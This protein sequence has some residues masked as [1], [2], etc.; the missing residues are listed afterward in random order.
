MQAVERAWDIEM[1]TKQLIGSVIDTIFKIVIIAVMVMFTYKYATEAYDFGYR[2][3]AEEP[4]SSPETAKAISIAI[5]EEAS[6]M[7]IGTVLEEKGLINDARLFYVQEMLSKYH[8]EIRPGI[9]ELSSDM[10]A[11]EMM[12]VMATPPAEE[13]PGDGA[14]AEGGGDAGNTEDGTDIEVEGSEDTAAE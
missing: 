12:A 5:T 10:T 1:N 8:D 4:V 14:A 9:Y 11:E 3:F 6:L 13:E 7:D 2:V